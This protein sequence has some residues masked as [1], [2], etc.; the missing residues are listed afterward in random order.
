MCAP[1]RDTG[2]S[3]VPTA[4]AALRRRGVGGGDGFE[5]RTVV[6]VVAV[7]VLTAMPAVAH[8]TSTAVAIINV[9]DA[10]VTYRLTLIVPEL[11]SPELF[12]AAGRGDAAAAT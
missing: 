5:M 11:A 8:T 9:A 7:L 12:A 6:L 3:S 1:R 4:A 2:A 10:T